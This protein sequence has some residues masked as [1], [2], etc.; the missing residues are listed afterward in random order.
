MTFNIL[1]KKKLPKVVIPTTTMQ[2]KKK[3]VKKPKCNQ[4]QIFWRKVNWSIVADL[5][6]DSLRG[7]W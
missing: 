6:K 5:G 4:R 7:I 3:K 1:L 2:K